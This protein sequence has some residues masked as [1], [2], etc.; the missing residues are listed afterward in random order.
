MKQ[1]I[2]QFVRLQT[3]TAGSAQVAP[4]TQSHHNDTAG[5]ATVPDTTTTADVV[6]A[7]VDFT[8]QT[9]PQSSATQ[10]EINTSHQ[11]NTRDRENIKLYKE[12][13]TS[14]GAPYRDQA[15]QCNSTD[16][17]RVED[18]APTRK[19]RN[20]SIGTRY[21]D[22]VDS[23]G[24]WNLVS[25][26]KAQSQNIG[27]H[28]SP[29]SRHSMG[30]PHTKQNGSLRGVKHEQGDR[31]Y[32]RNISITRDDEENDIISKIRIYAA[33]RGIRIM[34]ANVV[35]NRFV[36]DVVGCKITVPASQSEE[37]LITGFWPEDIE[38]RHWKTRTSFNKSG[39]GNARNYRNHRDG[40]GSHSE[41]DDR[42]C[43]DNSYSD[44][45]YGRKQYR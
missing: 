5:G 12:A 32:L 31:L 38:C 13:A 17:S 41:H 15:G 10:M 22:A 24:G 27:A 37:V 9:S 20:A 43:N 40:Y 19:E 33:N 18:S 29:L 42:Y 4:V 26:K 2:A 14:P 25:R 35:C 34:S 39:D 8:C 21:R 7:S 16:D 44:G 23:P 30:S 6:G 28:T 11:T 45:E 1:N 3:A 36:E